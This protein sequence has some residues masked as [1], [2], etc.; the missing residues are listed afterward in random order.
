MPLAPSK[1]LALLQRRRQVAELYLRSWTQTAIAE[2]LGVTQPTICEDLKRIRQ[3]WRESAIRDFDA[4]RE[5]ELQKLDLVERE[6]WAAWERSQQ[7]QESTRVT[8]DGSGKRAQKTVEHPVGDPRYL[9][10][11]HKCI[12]ARR[13]LL[14]LDAP[15]RIAPVMPDGEEPFRLAVAHLSLTEL[16]ALKHLRDRA[17]GVTTD[18]DRQADD[19]SGEHDSRVD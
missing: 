18:E 7:V 12:A 8:Q 6:A 4:A 16:R 3:Q 15:T 2:R 19:P 9:E 14:G 13:A 17:L 5:Q 10:Q 11:V 1:R